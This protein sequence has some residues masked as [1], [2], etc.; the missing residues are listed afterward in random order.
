M[1]GRTDLAIDRKTG[2]FKNF[3]GVDLKEYHK[4]NIK[5]TK[6]KKTSDSGAL[7]LKKDK[8]I[9]VT[10]EFEDLE[11]I[12]DYK[13]IKEAIT[14]E[15]L[16]L[17]EDKNNILVLA[18]GNEEITSDSIGPKT[19]KR[20]LATRHI[21]KEFLEKL[22]LEKLKKVSVLAPNVLGKTGIETSEIAKAVILKTKP[23]AAVII[24]ALAT[25]D[26]KRLFKTVQ[27]TNTGISPGSGVKNERK[28]L[29]FKTLGIP[30][31]AIGVPTVVDAESLAF[32]L[33]GEKSKINSGLFVTP[34]DCDILCEDISKIL[35]E[36]LNLALQ[37]ETDKETV[38]NLV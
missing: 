37:N 10:L 38:L 12:I 3:E 36:S 26:I 28:E 19:A 25:N 11:K 17:L 9:Y 6:M 31:I 27:I 13:F 20:L 4:N 21:K 30:V 14:E 18:L 33:T 15:I 32:N 34:K 23:Q 5:I 7:K 16:T 35:A 2:D 8:G 1:Y 29:S 24:D 22:N